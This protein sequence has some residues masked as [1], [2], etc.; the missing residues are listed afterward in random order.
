MTAVVAAVVTSAAVPR[1]LSLRASPA[2]PERGPSTSPTTT[3]NRHPIHR[4]SRHYAV[5]ARLWQRPAIAR[6]A[7]ATYRMSAAAASA[8]ARGSRCAAAGNGGVE[9]EVEEEDTVVITFVLPGENGDEDDVREVR[10]AVPPG[11][12]LLAAAMAGGVNR[13]E[14]ATER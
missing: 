8:S 5:A 14:H 11:G 2:S 1:A 6:Q 9:V 4:R 13:N 7:A 3:S 10:C 12:N